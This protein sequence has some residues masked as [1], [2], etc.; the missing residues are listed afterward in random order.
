LK[1]D[2]ENEYIRFKTR[3]GNGA[4]PDYQ[5]NPPSGK[6]INQGLEARD[7][8]QGDQQWVELVD[9]K[10]RGLWFTTKY[11]H[12]ILRSSLPTLLQY[13]D[14]PS[15]ALV[16]WNTEGGPISINCKANIEI[17]AGGNVNITAGGD[18]NVRAGDDVNI[19]AGND[20]N[21][22]GGDNMNVQA[23]QF[24]SVLGG[25]QVRLQAADTLFTLMPGQII[26]TNAK[27][28]QGGEQANPADSATTAAVPTFPDQIAP[29]DRGQTYNGP[30]Q[31]VD[32]SVVEHP[33]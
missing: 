28:E 1:L 19:T 12:V 6:G 7:G 33:T 25:Q 3:A 30:F 5:V 27:I 2:S 21:I 32:A 14:E 23:G 29:K 9:S 17:N 8:G 13:M 22:S 26:R 31:K 20:A 18:V 4:G 11:Q 24:V 15:K 10:N 16:L